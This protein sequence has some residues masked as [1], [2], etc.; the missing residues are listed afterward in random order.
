MKT[1]QEDIHSYYIK[2]NGNIYRP[3]WPERDKAEAIVMKMLPKE[4]LESL[5]GLKVKT[6]LWDNFLIV[7]LPDHDELWFN[8]GYYTTGRKSTDVFRDF[9]QEELFIKDLTDKGLSLSDA[10]VELYKLF[11]RSE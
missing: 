4:S 6:K 2:E 11:I 9:V 3:V 1:I 7:K 10:Y 5:K 8:H